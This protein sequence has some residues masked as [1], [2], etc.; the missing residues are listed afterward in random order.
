MK[1][2]T[3]L[4]LFFFSAAV[5]LFSPFCGVEKMPLSV[6][7]GDCDEIFKIIWWQLRVPR[8]LLGWLTGATLAVCGMIF[9]ALF[10][11][12]LASPDM[13]GVSSGAAFGVVTYIRFGAEFTLFGIFSG[14]S[15]AAFAGAIVA[16]FAIYLAGNMRHRAMSSAALLLAGIAI[17][18]LLSSLNMMLQY[19]GSY[20]DSFRALRW[21]VGGLETVGFS[22]V[23]TALVAFCVV[24]AVA[25]IVS[26]ELNL[27]VCGESLAESRGVNVAALRK[28]LFITVSLVIAVNV[29]VCGPIGFIGLLVPHICRYFAGRSHRALT[30]ASVL[31]GGAFLVLCDTAAR[32]LWSPSEVPVG[33]LT[34][35][36]GS[37]FFLSL[38]I[39]SS[40]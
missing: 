25:L 16:T 10:R 31:F 2:G 12:D 5:L 14:I 19:S 36:I 11:N 15:L 20:I 29:S 38:L 3:A 30:V 6:L 33:I 22:Q 9:Q 37:L 17:S 23:V 1:K 4:G 18:Y 40:D 27:F 32:V 39:R 8:V 24:F 34:A 13:L 26:P 28:F 21:S 35:F 7:W